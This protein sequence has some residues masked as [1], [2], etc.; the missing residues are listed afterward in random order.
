ML[1]FQSDLSVVSASTAG[2]FVRSISTKSSAHP[3]ASRYDSATIV[4]DLTLSTP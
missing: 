4:S 3:F 1:R 2:S